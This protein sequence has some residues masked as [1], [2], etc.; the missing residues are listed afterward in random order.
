MC[1]CAQRTT[2]EITNE[3]SLCE[4]VEKSTQKYCSFSHSYQECSSFYFSIE[5]IAHKQHDIQYVAPMRAHYQFVVSVLDDGSC[6]A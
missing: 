5:S 3:E 4:Q 6:L 2:F 1:M